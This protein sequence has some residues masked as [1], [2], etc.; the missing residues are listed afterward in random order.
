MPVSFA[1]A[2]NKRSWALSMPDAAG[3]STYAEFW[4]ARKDGKKTWLALFSTPAS[5]WVR[6]NRH[7]AWQDEPWHC[8]AIAVVAPS[9]AEHRGAGKH[10]VVWDC[11]PDDKILEGVV[12]RGTT[13][14]ARD[15]KSTQ[16]AF[17]EWVRANKARNVQLWYNTDNSA[18]GQDR[19]LELAMGRLDEWAAVGDREFQGADDVRI[20]GCVKINRR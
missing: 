1:A 13:A 17:V 14:S 7:S 6:N 18:S 8:W 11:D 9:A 15:M 3:R 5:N 16:R 4:T 20:R 2:A 12:G 10:V 19:C